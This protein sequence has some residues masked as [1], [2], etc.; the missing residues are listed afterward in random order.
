MNMSGESN[1]EKSWNEIKIAREIWP[2]DI[3]EILFHYK[4]AEI[5]DPKYYQIYK[6]RAR[7]YYVL[8]EIENFLKPAKE[9][10]INWDKV[11][12]EHI[13]PQTIKSKNSAKLGEWEKYLGENDTKK[14]RVYLNKIG[15]LTL[16]WEKLNREAQNKLFETKQKDHYSNSQ[17]ELNK[18]LCNSDKHKEHKIKDI[19]SRS[20]WLAEKAVEIWKF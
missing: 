14:H 17:I 11:H 1:D 16:L 10:I 9:K 8:G 20:E 12:L 15:N 5:I 7:L 18:K 2:P 6:D 13:M 4:K 19:I 3:E